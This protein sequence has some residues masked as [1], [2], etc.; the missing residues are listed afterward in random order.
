MEPD[1]VNDSAYQGAI[2]TGLISI[3]TLSIV[4]SK[5]TFFDEIHEGEEECPTS[6]EYID[7]D[8]PERNFHINCSIQGHSHQKVKRSF[9]LEFKK[10]YGLK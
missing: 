5:E 10:K 2:R 9:R 1:V 7:P 6:V 4:M 3:P 8:L